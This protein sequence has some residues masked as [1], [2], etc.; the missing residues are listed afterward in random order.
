MQIFIRTLVLIVLILQTSC[1]VYS[2][3]R[4]AN[5]NERNQL[6]QAQ[7][8]R[9]SAIESWVLKAKMGVKTGKK[10]GSATVNWNYMDQ[11]QEIELYGPFGGG[12]VQI[13]AT[14]DSA[15]LKDT[16]GKVI[17]GN[18]AEEVLHDRLG[19][20]VPFTELIMWSRGLPDTTATDIEIDEYGLLKSLNQGK[21]HVEYQEYRLINELILPRK[22]IISALPGTMEIY[23]DDGNYIGDELT[24]KFIMKRWRG[25]NGV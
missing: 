15:I 18:T 22:L 20:Q 7:K 19:W 9:N 2:P 12:R 25:I 11:S 6:W 21:W 13:S 3:T 8:A 23:D 5:L 4:S 1:A 24:V 10:G 17:V 14:A 16:K